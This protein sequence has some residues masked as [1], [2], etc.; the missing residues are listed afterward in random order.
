MVSEVEDY[1]EGRGWGASFEESESIIYA[2]AV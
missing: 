2:R 1:A